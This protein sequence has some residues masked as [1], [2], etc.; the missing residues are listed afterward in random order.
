MNC[1]EFGSRLHPFVDGELDVAETLA[2]ETHAAECPPCRSRAAGERRFR[3]LLRRQPRE[4]A[5]PEFRAMLRARLRRSARV[6]AIRPWLMVPAAA[7]A[8]ALMWAVLPGAS[9]SATLVSNLVDKHI[10]YA[11]ID[12]PA[13]FV[14]A[15]RAAVEAWFRQR[16]GLRVTVADFS[17]AG[18]RLA[19]ARIAEAGERKAAHVLYEKGRTLLSVFTV[20]AD[21][22]ESELAGTRVTYRG[23]GYVTQERKGYRTVSWTE[24]Q[25]VFGLVSM[26]DY[27]SILQCADTLRSERSREAR[28]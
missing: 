23:R 8:A 15:D 2:A 24:A 6:A 13:E 25:A 4:S 27:E 19:G 3:Q 21:V 26:L 1:R 9:P 12:Q 17:P 16:A 18:I 28:L 14:S 5:P 10:A 22:G 20:P 11:Q 7:A